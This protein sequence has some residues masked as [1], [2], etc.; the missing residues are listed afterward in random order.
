V[1]TTEELPRRVDYMP[2]SEVVAAARNPKLHDADGIAAS[3]SKHGLGELPLLDERTGRLVAGHGRIDDLRDRYQ[4]GQDPPGGVLVDAEGEWKVP[5]VR[6]WASTSDDAAAAYLIGSN[7]LTISGGW[8]DKELAALLGELRDADPAWLEA[9]GLNEQDLD[10][11]LALA[12]PDDLDEVAR[13][14]GE[15]DETD[16]WPVV[17]VKVP[18]HVAAAWRELVDE[19]DGDEVAALAALLDVDPAQPPA[20]KGEVWE[21]DR[22]KQ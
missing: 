13:R 1:T 19:H 17:R 8:D 20:D 21:P 6:G 12:A 9:T 4:R 11:L 5:V 10:D 18:K 16:T 15:P 7:G 3:I 2:L 14:V 22:T